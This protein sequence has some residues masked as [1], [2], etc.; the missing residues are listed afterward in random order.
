MRHSNQMM[1]EDL[2]RMLGSFLIFFRE[3]L[4]A[5]MIVSIMLAYL[6]QV[7]RRDRFRDVWIGVW[8][9]LGIAAIGGYIIFATIRQY[10]G[11]NLQTEIESI[12]YF[13]AAGILT[14][15]TFWMNRQSRQLKSDLHARLATAVQRETVW[16]IALVAF[17]T[18]GREGLETVVFMIAI[19]FKSSPLFLTVGAL[20]GACAGLFLS[21]LIYAMGKRINLGAFF[22]TMGTL[23]ML[24]AAGLLA[25]GVQDWQQLG[26]IRFG[27]RP[28]WNTSG[29]LNENTTLGDILHS[30]FGYADNPTALQL[31]SYVVYLTLMLWLFWRGNR[32]PSAERRA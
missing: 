5:S 11:T 13:V 12:T 9:A 1:R 31:G 4:E 32:R 6:K 3:S 23:L 28:L 24:F 22:N 30:F 15:M 26:W 2:F 29:L 17:V 25:D 19:A 18:V 20:I 16:T 21:Y 14:Y 10:D 7:G 8:S 27:A